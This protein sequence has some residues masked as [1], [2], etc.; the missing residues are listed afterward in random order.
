MKHI[1]SISKN[2]VSSTQDIVE[3]KNAH[4]S[5]SPREKPLTVPDFA[6]L[7]DLIDQHGHLKQKQKSGQRPLKDADGYIYRWEFCLDPDGFELSLDNADPRLIEALQRPASSQTIVYHFTRLSGTKRNT[8]GNMGFQV[9]LEDLSYD[10]RG[11]SEFAIMKAC[12][13]FRKDTSPFFPDHS[14]IIEK[15]E[16]IHNAIMNYSPD[17]PMEAI[18]N[19]S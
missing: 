8:K 4:L 10:L 15:V 14:V 16:E 7:N 13:L 3:N 11:R 6:K 17:I 12:E 18:E 2:V 19:A 1:G 5:L 9:L